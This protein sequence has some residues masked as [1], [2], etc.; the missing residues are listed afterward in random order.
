MLTSTTVY[1]DS[2]LIGSYPISLAKYVA[3]LWCPLMEEP[4]CQDTSQYALLFVGT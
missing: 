4:L 2:V 3:F 1:C